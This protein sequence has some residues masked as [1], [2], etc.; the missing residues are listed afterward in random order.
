M[1]KVNLSRL[2]VTSIGLL[3]CVIAF[4]NCSDVKFRKQ[5]E[6]LVAA[7]DTTADEPAVVP[8]V[9]KVAKEVPPSI[10][11]PPDASTA[12]RDKILH[13]MSSLRGTSHCFIGGIK[14]TS[15]SMHSFHQ[16]TRFQSRS[17]MLMRGFIALKFQTPM[18]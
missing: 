12:V 9:V 11:V 10:L 17:K 7:E 14:V 4:Q 13:S 3:I 8:P 16:V 2:V 6:P 5:L 15:Y 1:A 18:E